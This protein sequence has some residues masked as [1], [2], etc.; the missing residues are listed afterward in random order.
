MK[1][2]ITLF[3]IIMLLLIFDNAFVPFFSIKGFIPSVL[4]TFII[5]YSIVNESWEGLW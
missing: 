3:S 4:F 1:K 2:F 5:S